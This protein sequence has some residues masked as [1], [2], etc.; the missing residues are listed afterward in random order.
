[1]DMVTP[2]TWNGVRQLP[3]GSC[4]STS[5]GLRP[6]WDEDWL[7]VAE[8]A[9]ATAGRS[10]KTP[11]LLIVSWRYRELPQ[12]L[13]P[14]LLRHSA[15]GPR[16]WASAGG[17]DGTDPD[18]GGLPGLGGGEGAGGPPGFGGSKMGVFGP[19]KKGVPGPPKR[20]VRDT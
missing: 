9:S 13:T 8:A 11:S 3:Y 10:G 17:G 2:V 18:L 15:L 6:P 12:H 1:M 4:G 20:G 7:L 5:R 16:S 14:R 19:P